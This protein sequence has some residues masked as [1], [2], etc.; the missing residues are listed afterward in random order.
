MILQVALV[1]CGLFICNFAFM[2]LKFWHFR[3][4]DPP[5]LSKIFGHTICN[6][7]LCETVFRSI[8]IA[9]FE[10]NVWSIS[11][12]FFKQ[13][14]VQSRRQFFCAF[15]IWARKSCTKNDGKTST[16]NV[17]VMFC[18]DFLSRPLVFHAVNH[19]V[20]VIGGTTKSNNKIKRQ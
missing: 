17:S 11:P 19:A 16:Y 12:T 14:K 8:C 15:G 13:L 9:Y 6:F 20:E 3:C 5:K 2:R 18:H 7:N 10:L 1:L 4:T